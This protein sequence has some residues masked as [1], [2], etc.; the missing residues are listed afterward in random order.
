MDYL[1][2]S[3]I[4]VEKFCVLVKFSDTYPEPTGTS[5]VQ[6]YLKVNQYWNPQRIRLL[7]LVAIYQ[8]LFYGCI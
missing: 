5:E 2:R 8:I 6:V 3:L 4:F 1:S 7:V